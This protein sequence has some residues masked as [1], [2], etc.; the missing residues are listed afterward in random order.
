LE[1]HHQ[2]AYQQIRNGIIEE[3]NAVFQAEKSKARGY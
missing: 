2:L 1:E 3:Y